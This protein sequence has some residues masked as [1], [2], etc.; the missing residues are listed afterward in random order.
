MFADNNIELS[1]IISLYLPL[2]NQTVS[3]RMVM[4]GY[5]KLQYLK[6]SRVIVGSKT[7]IGWTG[8][9]TGVIEMLALLY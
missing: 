7:G 3:G 5:L 8:E 4:S 9:V 1:L 6:S 2:I